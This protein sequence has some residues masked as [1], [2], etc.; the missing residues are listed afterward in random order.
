[1]V[2]SGNSSRKWLIQVENGY[3]YDRNQADHTFWISW[4]NM[5]LINPVAFLY[6]YSKAVHIRVNGLNGLNGA[7]SMIIHE[8]PWTFMNIRGNPWC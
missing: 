3:F 4:E 2:K 1:M 8:K 6:S 7:F 5:S